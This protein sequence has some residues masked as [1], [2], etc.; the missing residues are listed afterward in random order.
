MCR[1]KNVTFKQMLHT[2]GTMCF[3]ILIW[4]CQFYWFDF[5]YGFDF[6]ILFITVNHCDIC[7][8]IWNITEYVLYK[9]ESI[10]LNHPHLMLFCRM[11]SKPF[12]PEEAR[13]IVQSLQKPA[14]FLNMTKDWPAL[15]WTVEHLSTCLTERVR[16]RIGKRNEDMGKPQTL[17]S[18]L[19]RVK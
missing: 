6:V 4:T 18:K 2:Q 1:C 3:Y 8:F 19:I 13:R 9:T 7:S 10:Y 5:D 12:T 11:A 16:F 14:V 17:N 15:H